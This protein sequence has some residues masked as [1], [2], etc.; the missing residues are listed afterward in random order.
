MHLL[1]LLT[2]IAFC[3]GANWKLLALLF[4]HYQIPPVNHL[5]TSVVKPYLFY[6]QITSFAIYSARL[7]Q[8]CS[9]KE[10]AATIYPD[11]YLCGEGTVMYMSYMYVNK[12]MIN[13]QQFRG[14]T[15]TQRF[16]VYNPWS[17]VG[18]EE[19]GKPEYLV[20]TLLEQGRE[21]IITS[22]TRYGIFMPGFEPRPHWLEVHMSSLTTT[23]PLFPESCYC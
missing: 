12:K 3:T 5:L 1:L 17:N 15:S 19:R 14:S 11:G 21:P 6:S 20:K 16:L 2:Q 10:K 8:P 13:K 23:P 4:N 18:F 9:G 7:L 22:S